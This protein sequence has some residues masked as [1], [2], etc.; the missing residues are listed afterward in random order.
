MT[1]VKRLIYPRT[2][3]ATTQLMY[4]IIVSFNF[5]TTDARNRWTQCTAQVLFF[6]GL[7]LG[8][9]RILIGRLID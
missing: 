3:R 4:L 5:H 8:L 9:L 7:R 2:V 1:T 6:T